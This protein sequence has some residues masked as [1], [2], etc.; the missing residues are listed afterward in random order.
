[1]TRFKDKCVP[2]TGGGSG[3]GRIMGRLA[4]ERDRTPR[5]IPRRFHPRRFTQG[6]L[7]RACSVPS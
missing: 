4:L 7:P 3:I 6:V 2:V 5:G 1:M